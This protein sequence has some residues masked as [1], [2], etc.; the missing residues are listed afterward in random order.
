[1]V[2][3]PARTVIALLILLLSAGFLFFSSRRSLNAGDIIDKT[4]KQGKKITSYHL[5]LEM[6]FNLENETREHFAQVWYRCP[7]FFRVEI[8]PGHPEDDDAEPD[9]VIVSDG[10]EMWLFSPEIGD[11]F[12]LSPSIQELA[13]TPFLL[14]TFLNGLARSRESELLGTEKKE[15]H[16]YYM[17]RVIPP[18]PREDHAYE[19]IW[20]ERR[21]LL[22]VQILIYDQQDKLK[23]RVLFHKTILNADIPEELFHINQKGGAVKQ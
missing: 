4:L 20:L 2:S 10:E 18:V 5:I 12:I 23:Q 16:V 3:R 7:H 19:E 6:E 13:P 11:H 8:F 15:R 14:N 17:L 1:M 22:P 21:T 9:Q